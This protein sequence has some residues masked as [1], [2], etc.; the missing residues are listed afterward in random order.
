MMYSKDPYNPIKFLKLLLI[1]SIIKDL[2]TKYDLI[3]DAILG[4]EFSK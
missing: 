3:K 1:I 4:N 2:E